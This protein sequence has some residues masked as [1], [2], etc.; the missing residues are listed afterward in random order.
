MSQYEINQS[1][2][3]DTVKNRNMY[4]TSSTGLN[5]N[6]NSR[7]INV[8]VS[9]DDSGQDMA[10]EDIENTPRLDY[11][12][13]EERDNTHLEL[14]QKPQKSKIVWSPIEPSPSQ[15]KYNGVRMFGD[16][17]KN[18][19]KN[20]ID[21]EVKNIKPDVIRTKKVSNLI[22]NTKNEIKN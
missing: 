20:F 16:E 9:T 18:I 15:E 17:T 21:E 19:L 10:S 1:N 12:G 4:K 22:S 8:N 2:R 3:N 14:S 6:A 5:T 11:T 13:R 7:N